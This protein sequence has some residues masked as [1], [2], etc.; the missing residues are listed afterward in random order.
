MIIL[1]NTLLNILFVFIKKEEITWGQIPRPPSIVFLLLVLFNSFISFMNLMY[2][3]TIYTRYKS[4]NSIWWEKFHS[5]PVLCK[6][7][8]LQNACILA[9]CPNEEW[10]PISDF[11]RFLCSLGCYK[12]STKVVACLIWTNSF[13]FAGRE[14]LFQGFNHLLFPGTPVSEQALL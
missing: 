2:G 1:Y 4:L 13:F 10:A 6:F 11:I 3:I 8:K 7:L 12:F 14:I 9:S 5:N